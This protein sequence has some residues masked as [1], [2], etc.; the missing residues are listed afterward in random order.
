LDL[1]NDLLDMSKIEA[2]QFEMADEQVEAVQLIR[3][4]VN[5][6]APRALA[7]KVTV[8]IVAPPSGVVLRADR[9]AVRQIVLNLLSN[10]VKFTPA[11]GTVTVSLSLDECGATLVVAD[12]GIGIAKESLARLG[13]PFQQVDASISRRFG[14]TGL[15]LAITRK[16][17]ALHG[18]SLHFES[19]PG[20]GTTVS[21]CFPIG[22]IVTE[23]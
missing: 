9:R 14:G 7:D 16:L 18:G 15:G 4:C 21:A 6:I 13:E 10:A 19:E 22:R 17:L 8:T 1:I 11:G 5:M 2:G 12:T 23:G 3:S 20:R